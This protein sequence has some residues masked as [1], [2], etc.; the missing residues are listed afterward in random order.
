M[1]LCLRNWHGQELDL[2]TAVDG[3]DAVHETARLCRHMVKVG[4]VITSVAVA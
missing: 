4:W 1:R 2:A 3:K